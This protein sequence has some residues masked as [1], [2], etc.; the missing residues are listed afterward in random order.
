M[1]SIKERLGTGIQR[2]SSLSGKKKIIL[3]VII[4]L[5]FVSGSFAA[6]TYLFK[7]SPSYHSPEVD[8]HVSFIG[9]RQSAVGTFAQP[10]RQLLQ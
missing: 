10:N 5:I 8:F 1:A 2:I 4:V 9:T 3:S 7:E 6:I